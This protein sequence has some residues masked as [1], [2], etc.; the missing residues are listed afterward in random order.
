MKAAQLADEAEKARLIMMHNDSRSRFRNI[1]SPEVSEESE[2]EEDADVCALLLEKV[3][4]PK[5]KTARTLNFTDF[6]SV[7]NEMRRKARNP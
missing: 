1:H 2:L 5:A 6:Y 3:T 7:M 4:F